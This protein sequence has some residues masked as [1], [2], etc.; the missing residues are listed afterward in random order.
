MQWM[1]PV[2]FVSCSLFC[3]ASYADVSITNHTDKPATGFAGASPCSN[4]AGTLGIILPGGNVV[5][6]QEALDL[7]CSKGCEVDVFMSKNCS[8]KKVAAISANK[9][10]VV[11]VHNF[12][13]GYEIHGIGNAIEIVKA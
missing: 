10:G 13:K 4:T 5:V 12:G 11:S 2:L 3:F 9:T 7:Y 1:K 6:P 8:G